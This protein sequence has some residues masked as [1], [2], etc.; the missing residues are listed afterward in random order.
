MSSKYNHTGKFYS[1][2]YHVAEF[3]TSLAFIL[4]VLLMFMG[5]RYY[6]VETLFYDILGRI[7]DNTDRRIAARL[8]AVVVTC[9][10]LAIMVHSEKL[11]QDHPGLIRAALSTVGMFINLAFWQPWSSTDQFSAWGVSIVLSGIDWVL[12][13]LFEIR[14]REIVERVADP[15]FTCEHCGGT[16]NTQQGK[17]AH[18]CPGKQKNLKKKSQK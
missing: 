7:D 12:P 16:W 1:K 9:F 14:W 4:L 2:V 3:I 13:Y 15:V 11:W 6:E 5:Y 18:K 10:T 8:I 17:N